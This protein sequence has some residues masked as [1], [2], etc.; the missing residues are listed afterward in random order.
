MFTHAIFVALLYVS[1]VAVLLLN[2]S[3]GSPH[4]LPL[5]LFL[6]DSVSVPVDIVGGLRALIIPVHGHCPF[7]FLC[8]C[9]CQAF[10]NE[11]AVT[12]KKDRVFFVESQN[13]YHTCTYFCQENSYQ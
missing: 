3:P 4:I 9:A 2:S 1:L 12:E 5:V 8:S 6:H 13:I 10:V 11:T 7:M